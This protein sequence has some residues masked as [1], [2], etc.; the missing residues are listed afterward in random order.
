MTAAGRYLRTI[1]LLRPEQA[2]A[3]ARLRAQRAIPH[4]FGE[5]S[6]RTIGAAARRW[7]H[8]PVVTARPAVAAWPAEFVPFD[9]KL[10]D[11]WPPAD[12]LAMGRFT[13]LGHGRD[14]GEPA[15]W[16]QREAPAL[17]R[18]H[19][20]Y[21]DWA[22]A[23]ALHPDRCWAHDVFSALYRSWR[24]GTVPGRG[25]AW[26]PYVVSLRIWSWCGLI[27]R[28]SD[29]ATTAADASATAAG[30]M[31]SGNFAL[32]GDSVLPTMSA[33]LARHATFLRLHLE[34]DVGGNHLLKNVKAL[35][36]AAVALDDAPATERWAARLV[37][38]IGRQ[39][40]ADGGH[41]ERAPAY[42]CQVLADLD[43]VAGLLKAARLDVPV[44]I[45]DARSRMRSWLGAVLT[46]DGG[47][48]LLNDGYPVPPAAVAALYPERTA[49][50][51]IEVRMPDRI[52]GRRLMLL[53]ASGLAVLQAGPWWVLADV[54]LPC[55]NDLPAHAHAD[56][57]SFLL[58]Y[59]GQ[60]LFTEVGTSTYAAGPVRAAERSTAAHNTVVVD[61]HDSTEVWGTF[62]AGRRARVD[63]GPV[64]CDG[65]A[66]PLRLTASHD[67][68]RWL[69]GR[70]QHTRTWTLD[71]ETLRITDRI[72]GT[73][74]HRIEVL[75]HLAA[76]WRA[77]PEHGGLMLEHDQRSRAFHLVAAGA[78]AGTGTWQ[79]RADRLAV[80]WQ[81]T[82]PAT[83][84][85]YHVAARL[86]MEI[87]SQIRQRRPSNVAPHDRIT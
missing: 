33:D 49:G 51:P 55:P 27:T 36:G 35:L 26:A 1:T 78:G 42:H 37:A 12:K 44:E 25:D 24:R 52:E 82:T 3:R 73:G 60:P 19:L 29:G 8:R 40:L 31:L 17:W 86:P 48:P 68:Y 46:P 2:V 30:T 16:T 11:V 69:R 28:L 83:V 71:H 13:L 59:A 22:W 38:E 76:G 74:E 75:F 18:Y 64:H 62:R 87:Q 66:G 15:D 80:G 43:D 10:G 77:R 81:Q 14:L 4:R 47:V 41:A 20:H 6:M 65:A 9:A 23:L 45:D 67:G 32:P 79:T 21:W 7:P 58:W 5:T 84:A 54:G 39:V 56:T 70:P 53:P 72:M 34:T 61:G 57:L 63:L 50:R 85:V